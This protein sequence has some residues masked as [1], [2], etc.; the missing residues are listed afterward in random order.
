MEEREGGGRGEALGTKA[1]NKE[2]ER[3]RE[4]ERDRRAA[5][6]CSD[7]EATPPERRQTAALSHS[8]THSYTCARTRNVIIQGYGAPSPGDN[9]RL[10]VAS[11]LICVMC[12]VR[13]H[14][15]NSL[16]F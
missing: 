16:L 8:G 2:G 14:I 1:R 9:G 11:H 7:G 4:R 15:V 3:E 12:H 6:H 13:P 5:K 10:G